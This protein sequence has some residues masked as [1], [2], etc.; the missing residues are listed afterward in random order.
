MVEIRINQW[1]KSSPRPSELYLSTLFELLLNLLCWLVDVYD[2]VRREKL[3]DADVFDLIVVLHT[4][5][6]HTHY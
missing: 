5:S 6:P 4:C 3:A 2:E 1:R